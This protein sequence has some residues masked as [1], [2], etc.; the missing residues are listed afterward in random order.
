MPGRPP[1]PDERSMTV[2]VNAVEQNVDAT[3]DA[4]GRVRKAR[5]RAMEIK[6]RSML[7]IYKDLDEWQRYK[8]AKELLEE[9][10]EVEREA[11]S[12]D[13]EANERWRAVIPATGGSNCA[14]A[15]LAVKTA[16]EAYLHSNAECQ[17]IV[18]QLAPEVRQN[19]KDACP[20]LS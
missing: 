4:A 13:T 15:R 20:Q 18:D 14:F 1:Q 2:D 9:V 7:L 19:C 8:E 5:D 10:E 16:K 11:N 3:R 17:L 12:A 6:N